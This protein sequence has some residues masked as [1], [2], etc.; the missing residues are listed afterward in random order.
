MKRVWL[1]PMAV[2]LAACSKKEPPPEPVR[3]VLSVK[4]EA[5]SEES[6]GRFAGSIQA[7]YESNTG[8]RVGG[9]IASRNVDVGAEV[10]PGDTLATLDPTDQQNQL[11]A[12]EGDLARVEAQ[13]INAQANARRQQELFDRG[14]GAQAQLDIAQTDLK[15]TG[16]S[17]AQA[18]AAVRQAQDQLNYSQLRSDHGGVVTAM[19]RR[20]QWQLLGA[21]YVAQGLPFG[22]FTVALPVLMRDAGWSLTAIS[23]L[24]FLALPW[25]LK[26]LWAPVLDHHGSRRLWLRLF[27][28]ASCVLALTLSQFD[29]ASQLGE[30]NGALG[31]TAWCLFAAVL[32]FNLMAASQDVVTD[33]LAVRLLN[34]PD[35]GLA[36]GLQ[37]GGFRLGMILGGGVLLWVFARSDWETMFIGMAALLA[38]LALASWNPPEPARSLPDHERPSGLALGWAWWHRLRAPGMVTLALLIVAYRLGDQMISSL[39]GP[40]LRDAGMDKETI[41]MIRGVAGSATSLV[42]SLVGGW[43][44]FR[45]GRR[46]ALLIGGLAQTI[47]F[48]FYLAA[49]NG[50]SVIESIWIATLLEGV[51]GSMATVAL[52]T[53]M[54]DAADPDHAGTDFTILACMTSL[55]SGLANLVGGVLGD[56]LGYAPTFATA[57]ALSIAGTLLV[58][59]WL[60]RHP[61]H[62]RMMQAWR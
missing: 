49:A 24:Q 39:T 57:T 6:L 33:G 40:F 10:K 38:L 34:A 52:Y 22:F 59:G 26:F 30:Q 4:V 41:A 44:A 7:R 16:A 3:P 54:M 46:K 23:L 13:W 29:L 9:R 25:A 1:L 56:W 50:I 12:A 42:G 17:L 20:Q 19:G 43:V 31:L 47:A 58:V 61:P 2:L 37:I 55:A 35:R 32:L 27:Q 53:F 8:F 62:P 15:T 5:L 21:L 28:G 14:V 11:R 51:L 48:A 36:N 45:M 18:K 60:E